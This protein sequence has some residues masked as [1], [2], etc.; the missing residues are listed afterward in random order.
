MRFNSHIRKII[1]SRCFPCTSLNF[2]INTAFLERLTVRELILSEVHIKTNGDSLLNLT[3]LKHSAYEFLLSLLYIFS[4]KALFPIIVCAYIS[5]LHI[6]S[7][8]RFL[9]QFP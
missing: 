2:L 1:N 8:K 3:Y 6:V 4:A 5:S 7:L 9:A